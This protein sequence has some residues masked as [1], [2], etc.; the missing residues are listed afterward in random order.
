MIIDAPATEGARAA[1]GRIQARRRR[2]TS[3]GTPCTGGTTRR[4]RAIATRTC[5]RTRS[6]STTAASRTSPSTIRATI[7][8]D[9][10]LIYPGEE[11]L[12]PEEDRGIAGPVASMQLANLRRGL[13][14]HQY[15]TLA[16]QRGLT[17]VVDAAL[18][19]VVP[20]VFSDAGDRVSFPETGRSVRGAR[21]SR[22]EERSRP[23]TDET[24]DEGRMTNDERRGRCFSRANGILA[25]LCC[26]DGPAC[27]RADGARSVPGDV[28][29]A[30]GGSHPGRP[31]GLPARQPVERGHLDAPR[32]PGLG[33][34]HRQHRRGEAARLQPR[35]ELRD[36]AARSAAGARARDDVSGGVGSGAVSGSLQR[37]DRE[38]A[39]GAQ[40]R[41]R[42][43]AEAGRDAGAVPARRHRR[44]PP[45]HRRSRARAAARVLAGAADRHRLGGIA[46][47]D[48]RSDVERAASATAGRP[49]TR[50]ACRSSR[51]SCATTRSPGARS[52]TRCVSP[53]AAR[54]AP[55]SIPRAISPALT[56]IP[57]CRGWASGCGSRPRSI[58][59][60]SRRTR[61]RFSRG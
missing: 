60:D 46:G 52:A 32:C 47:L 45:D 36:R 12:H 53:C 35:H 37:A 49:P 31:A 22:S 8:G 24:N 20:R 11:R 10:V 27:E 43:A 16:R 28:R 17:G 48:V 15:L 13:Q 56:R 29:H 33:G 58:R 40:R 2:S 23:H 1:V 6:R 21:G 41:R 54:D 51:P 3:S 5:G 44:S 26:H 55:T 25:A 50:R 59:R 14:D 39:A 61:V 57:R 9:G 7:N 19:A 30:G 38:L 4:S 34:H 42:R 18:A